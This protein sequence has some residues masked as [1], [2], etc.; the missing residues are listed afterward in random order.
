M[1][2]TWYQYMPPAN[3]PTQGPHASGSTPVPST[4]PQSQSPLRFGGGARFLSS[5]KKSDSA[6]KEFLYQQ[7]VVDEEDARLSVS[8]FVVIFLSLYL[9]SDYD[10]S[11]SNKE[12]VGLHLTVLTRKTITKTSP[13]LPN[14]TKV[15]PRRATRKMTSVMNKIVMQI[16]LVQRKRSL[17]VPAVWP[18]FVFS[19][20]SF[21]IF[22]PDTKFQ[23]KTPRQVTKHVV[24]DARWVSSLSLLFS[25]AVSNRC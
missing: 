7:Q 3:S 12:S 6:Y 22:C 5:N 25:S 21:K 14:A 24:R 4:P 8:R 17:V 2:P 23:V 1:T 11:Q 10:D 19:S 13:G 15:S 16:I 9:C 18:K 20:L